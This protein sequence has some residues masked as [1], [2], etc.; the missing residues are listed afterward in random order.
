MRERFL[1]CKRIESFGSEISF[2]DFLK[3]KTFFLNFVINFRARKIA[4]KL[5]AENEA[6]KLRAND[7]VGAESDSKQGMI[8]IA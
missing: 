4:F 5:L 7:T 2:L 3:K 8:F 6:A 1:H